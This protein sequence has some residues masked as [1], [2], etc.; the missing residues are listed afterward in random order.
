MVPLYTVSEYDTVLHDSEL[1]LFVQLEAAWCGNCHEVMPELEAI[2]DRHSGRLAVLRVDADEE[3]EIKE[4]YQ[5]EGYPTYLFA[6]NGRVTASCLDP[7]GF[8]LTRLVELLLP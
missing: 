3:P 4:R 8:G 7:P 1:P 2:A 6:E 5:V